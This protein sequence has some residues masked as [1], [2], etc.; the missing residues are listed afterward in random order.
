MTEGCLIQYTGPTIRGAGLENGEYYEVL[1]GRSWLTTVKIRTGNGTETFVPVTRFQNEEPQ[2]LRKGIT[3]FGIGGK[4]GLKK[5]E[6]RRR[7]IT[8]VR[9]PLGRLCVVKKRDEPT[10]NN[11]R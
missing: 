6:T 8:E 2:R 3:I 5:T 1:D 10:S 4:F 9:T 11:K 7:I